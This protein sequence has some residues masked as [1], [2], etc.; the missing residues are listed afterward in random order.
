MIVQDSP[1]NNI[2]DDKF[3]REPIVDLIVD[4]INQTVK[5]EHDCMVYGIYGKWGEGKTSLMNFIKARLLSQGK[6][7]G[8]NLVEFNPWLVNNDESLLREFFQSIMSYPDAI[9]KKAF[10]K[11]GSLAIF[12]SKTIIN[13]AAPGI[14]SALAR[15]IKWAQ[16]ALEDSQDSLAEL[17]TKVSDAIVKSARHLIVM[18]DDVDRLDKEELHTVLRLIRQVADFKNCIYIVA[19]DVDMVA[20]AIGNH[21]GGGSHQDGR[22]FIDKIVLIPITLPQIPQCDML[23]FVKEELSVILKDVTSV[24]QVTEIAKTVLPFINTYR[25]LKRYCNQISF[26]LPHLAGEVN[27][28]DLCALEAIKMVNATAYRRIYEKEEALRHIVVSSTA[29]L[30][31]D[32]GRE[33][34]AKNYEEAKEWVCEGMAGRLRDTVDDT[35]DFLFNNGSIFGQDDMDKKRLDTDVYFQKYFTQLVPG[36]LI[37][38]RVLDAFGDK[39][40]QLTVE[41]AAEQF[42]EWL[43]RYSSSEV[44]RSSLYF[45]RKNKERNVQCRTAS[46]MAKALSISQLA[47]GLPPHVYVD[48]IAITAFVAIQI[49]HN[50]MFVQDEQYAHKNVWDERLL[51]DTLA[52]IF[53]K[54]EM[55]YCIG[56]LAS[57]DGILFGSGVYDGR[58]V[59]SVLVKRFLEMGFYEQFKYSKFLLFTFLNRWRRVAT[60]TFN[61]Y[62]KDLFVN[63]EHDMGTILNKFIDDTDDGQDVANFVGLFKLQVPQINERLQGESEEVRTSHAAK[64]YASNYRP[65][66]G[67]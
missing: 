23:G 66:I 1:L 45:I 40:G 58:K 9:V 65:L 56:L 36:D 35:L 42:D 39:I 10:K 30:A 28:H 49:I 13:A 17:K 63:P 67:L 52:F 50:F 24:E 27:I 53:E 18:I 51:D 26:I 62:A 33:V 8:I 4:S 44:K 29:L 54:A 11:Y 2:A 57:A 5:N 47:K 46:M 37:P 60:D 31:A 19:M 14:G 15:G 48:E 61:E 20:K 16:K 7:D 34:A 21:Y 25:D 43:E 6:D 59:M 38:D 41:D 22:K 55:N 12:A 64:I 32:K 3:G